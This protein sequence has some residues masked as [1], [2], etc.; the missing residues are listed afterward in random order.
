MDISQVAKASGLPASTLR[1]YEEKGL[2][3]SIGRQGL[4]RVFSEKVLERLA[5]ISLGRSAGFT[6]EELAEMFREDG[7]NINR[8]LLLAKAEELDAKIKELTTMRDGLRHAAAC[9]A[10]SHFECPTFLRILKIAGKN[11]LKKPDSPAHRKK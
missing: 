7:N 9:Q 6:L 4:K 11:R 8:T 5:L 10:P 2:I 1:F 3:E